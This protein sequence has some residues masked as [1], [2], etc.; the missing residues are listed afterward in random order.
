MLPFPSKK[1]SWAVMGARLGR[2]WWFKV[3]LDKELPSP[4]HAQEC[5]C[6]CRDLRHLLFHQSFCAGSVWR[7][8]G[9]HILF[10]GRILLVFPGSCESPQS[11]PPRAQLGAWHTIGALS[12]VGCSYLCCPIQS[13]QATCGYLN[14]N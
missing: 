2:G 10:P 6:L 14:I 8:L 13:P 1:G 3:Q 9:S 12:G 5:P 7:S 11:L 4:W